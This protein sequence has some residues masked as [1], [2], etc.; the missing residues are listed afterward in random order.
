[1]AVR[2][3]KT[4]AV[5]FLTQP[6]RHQ[7]L[8][9]VTQQALKRDRIR[10]SNLLTLSKGSVAKVD[11]SAPSDSRF[12]RYPRVPLTYA[13]VKG[14]GLVPSWE[15]LVPKT[16]FG[17]KTIFLLEVFSYNRTVILAKLCGALLRGSGR[18]EYLCSVPLKR[19]TLRI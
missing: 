16:E 1:M 17:G 3:M 12:G 14:P 5:E 11:T 10:G 18:K 19:A 6:F 8:L 15:E 13:G 9:D 2:A 4:G 7:D